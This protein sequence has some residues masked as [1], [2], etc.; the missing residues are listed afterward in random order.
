MNV[1][2]RK[3]KENNLSDTTIDFSIFVSI[4]ISIITLSNLILLISKFDSNSLFYILSFV[5]N[6]VC[7][8][9]FLSKSFVDFI[10]KDT[11]DYDQNISIKSIFFENIFLSFI[12][13][14]T[15]FIILH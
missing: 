6:L 13:L 3:T 5:F 1:N 4:I 15:Y 9:F 10:V 8:L 7:F 12:L 2:G 11:F 14:N